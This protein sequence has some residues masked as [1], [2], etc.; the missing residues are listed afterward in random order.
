MDCDGACVDHKESR[1]GVELKE[2][3]G[4]NQISIMASQR[5]WKYT[6]VW[7]LNENNEEYETMKSDRFT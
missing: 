7:F 4:A 1:I 3:K 5:K 6:I 2:E